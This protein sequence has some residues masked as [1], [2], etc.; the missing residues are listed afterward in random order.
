MVS[1]SYNVG[2]TF[3]RIAIIGCSPF[4]S[5]L[6][7]FVDTSCSTLRTHRGA[8]FRFSVNTKLLFSI[9]SLVTDYFLQA[10][11]NLLNRIL[12]KILLKVIIYLDRIRG[13][14]T[15]RFIQW[16]FID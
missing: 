11:M 5:I 14:K 15:S 12:R 4:E 7:G 1:F 16:I 2:L 3:L 10:L 13:I 6:G 8:L 9:I